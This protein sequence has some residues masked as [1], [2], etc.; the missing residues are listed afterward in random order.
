[1]EKYY[2]IIGVILGIIWFI[3][4]I[5]MFVTNKDYSNEKIYGLTLGLVGGTCAIILFGPALLYIAVWI[6]ILLGIPYLLIKGVIKLI[7]IIKHYVLSIY[8]ER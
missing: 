4:S 5:V 8:P 1:M 3:G 6:G 7:K 2:F